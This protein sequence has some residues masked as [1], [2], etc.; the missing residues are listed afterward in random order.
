M[1]RDTYGK[2]TYTKKKLYKKKMRVYMYKKKRNNTE[3]GERCNKL[4]AICYK[5]Q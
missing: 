5:M 2:G 1:K 4:I 3:W